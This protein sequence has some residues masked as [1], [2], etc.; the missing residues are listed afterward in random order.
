MNVSDREL[1]RRLGALARRADAPEALWP[2]IER[3]IRP[4][5]GRRLTG[6]SVAAGVCLAILAGLLVTEQSFRNTGPGAME[7][8]IAAEMAVMRRIAPDPSDE[9]VR[10]MDPGLTEGWAVNQAAIDELEAAL[11]AHPDNRNLLDRLA[12]A[13]VRQTQ[14]VNRML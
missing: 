9:L 5:P 6:L 2:A 14:L 10:A 1:D 7:T 11:A 3:R 13:R 8:M 4:A 12:R